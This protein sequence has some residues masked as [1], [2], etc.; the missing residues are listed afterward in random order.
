LAEEI[1]NDLTKIPNLKV[2]ARTS[3]FQFKG[4]SEDSRMIGQRLNVRNF[5]EGSVRRYGSRVRI[6]VQLIKADDGFHVW[7]ESYDRDFKDIF[8]VEDEIAAAVTSAL[9]PRLLGRQSSPTPSASQTTNP[10]AYQAFLQARYFAR[11]NDTESV[12][13]AFEY[14]NR[15]IQR[16]PNYAPA[17][18]L[19]G[20]ITAEAG[21]MGRMNLSTAM[22]KSR[23]DAEKAIALDP[24][25]AAGYLALSESQ[26]MADWDW[27]GA[28]QSVRKARELAPVDAYALWQSAF[29]AWCWGRLEEAVELA[30]QAHALDPLQANHTGLGQILRDLGRY[31]EAQAVLKK[32]VELDPFQVWAHE[33]R[34][35]VYLA[36]GRPQEAMAEMEKEPEKVWR[37]YGMALAYHALGRRRDSDAA[38]AELIAHDQ[39]DAAYQVAEVYAYRG[40][41][42]QAFAWLD[43]AYRQRDAGLG[44]LRTEL[45][46]RNLRSDPR[47]AQ[48]LKKVN[49]AE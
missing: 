47:Y 45:L 34:G 42:D 44:H 48:L 6:T 27:Q 32:S 21:L 7:S 43:R 17:Y 38:L 3:A 24:N 8:A 5:L 40:E 28:E 22:E 30:R 29:L 11:R 4:K 49:L 19:R 39:N 18:A 36:Q 10:E 9:Q 37:D 20:S 31:E 16:D 41:T 23:R 15:A 33:V 25:L 1:L 14:I 13:K 46:L 26:A 2:A 35:E 12:Q